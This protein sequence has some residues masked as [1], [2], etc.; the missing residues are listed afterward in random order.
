MIYSHTLPGSAVWGFL[1][2]RGWDGAGRG[3]AWGYSPAGDAR[4]G[5]R[6]GRRWAGPP[7]QAGRSRR[8]PSAACPP[9]RQYRLQGWMTPQGGSHPHL[10]GDTGL[11]GEAA[12]PGAGH[13][14]GEAG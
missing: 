4:G 11:S 5:G 3:G 6:P 12:G 2:Q 8:S 1:P 7:P 14:G 9:A 13:G 10:R